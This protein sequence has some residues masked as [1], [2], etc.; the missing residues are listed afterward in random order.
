MKYPFKHIRLI[1]G[2]RICH[3]GFL[4]TWEHSCP[5]L[6]KTET[7]IAFHQLRFMWLPHVSLLLRSN[8]IIS[9]FYCWKKYRSFNIFWPESKWENLFLVC[10]INITVA[11]LWARIIKLISGCVV[12]TANPA[13]SAFCA[14]SGITQVSEAQGPPNAVLSCNNT[15]IPSLAGPAAKKAKISLYWMWSCQRRH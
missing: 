8:F 6:L 4:L 11:R 2:Y 14:V 9:C 15:E 3:L 13:A 1:R 12:W 7:S 5:S 10:I